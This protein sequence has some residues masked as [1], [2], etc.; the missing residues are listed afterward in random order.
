MTYVQRKR[1]VLALIDL[2]TGRGMDTIVAS[3][4]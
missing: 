1:L 3:G 4:G 2:T